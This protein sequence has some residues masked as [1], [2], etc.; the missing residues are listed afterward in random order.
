M[1]E[2]T[3]PNTFYVTTPIYYVNSVAHIGHAYT[4]TYADVLHR[5]HKLFGEESFFLTGTDEHGQKVEQAA[6]K[7]G[8]ATIE[9][10]NEMSEKFKELWEKMQ[11]IPSDFI[12]TTEERHAKVVQEMLQKLYDEKLIYAAEYEGYYEV[13]EERFLTE[14]EIEEKNYS[15]E[16]PEV[17]FLKEKSYF[18]KMGQYQSWLINHINENPDFIIPETRKNEVLGFLNKPLND[19][20]ISRPKSRMSWGIDLPFDK[21]YVTYVWFDA[22]L[23]YVSIHLS[24]ENGKEELQKWWPST[25]HLI[26]KDILTT[27]AVYWPTMLKALGFSMPKTIA[28]HGWW[29]LG[30]D[31]M[32]KSKGNVVNPLELMEKYGIEEFRYFLVREMSFGSDANFSEESLVIRLNTELSNDLGNLLSRTHKL[33]M[34]FYDGKIPDC[35][36]EKKTYLESE[37]AEVV[38]HLAMN[39]EKEVRALHLNLAVEETVLFVRKLNKYIDDVKP[40]SLAKNEETKEYAGICLYTVLDSLKLV[41]ELLSPIMPEKMTSMMQALGTQKSGLLEV[42]QLNAGDELGE[43]VNLFPRI[44]LNNE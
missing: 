25:T 27:H 7:K 1:K 33:V 5:F 42:G 6:V 18:F 12:R 14:K 19:L 26:G 13:S 11:I 17:V 35:K 32:S 29:L 21:D 16:G 3:S 34:K 38:N 20:C 30:Q 10:C 9:H 2:N 23:N 8:V 37:L 36:K 40:W 22:L 43:A 28:V 44:V 41:A 24:R 15:K 4:T 39:V 31:K